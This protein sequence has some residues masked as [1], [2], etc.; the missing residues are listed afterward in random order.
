MGDRLVVSVTADRFVKK[1]PGRPVFCAED[2]ARMLRALRVVDEVVVADAA[3]AVPVI[4]QLRP[5]VYVK[6]SDY[7]EYDGAGY[8]EEERAAVLA[9]GGELRFTTGRAMSSTAIINQHRPVVS[10]DAQTFLGRFSRRYSIDRVHGWLDR[11]ASLRVA[12]YGEH[13]ID[14]Y[15][16]VEPRGKASKEPIVTFKRDG[17]ER[18]P[19]GAM[20]VANHLRAIGCQVD[21]HV[22]KPLVKR[23][24]VTKPFYQKIFSVVQKEWLW[25]GIENGSIAK[26]GDYDLVVAADFG[27]GALGQWEIQELKRLAKRIALTAQSNSLN[28]GFNPLTRWGHVKGLVV[29]DNVEVRLAMQ[30]KGGDL[31]DV[32]K[33]LKAA[34]GARACIATIGHE[35]CLMA[36]S[37]AMH[38]IP[39]FSDKIVDRMGAGDAF[40]AYAAAIDAVGAPLEVTGFVG[41]IAGALKIQT[42]GNSEPVK[43]QDV[44]QWVTGL[45]K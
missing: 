35:G 34:M 32:L 19:G 24:Y 11:A 27:H 29:G 43:A 4:Q 20:A 25:G 40:L 14:E 41:N 13:I 36:G 28:F 26:A 21:T 10:S 8:L 30:D 31:A 15:V 22:S 7:Q 18:F 33:R 5:A 17:V 39:A 1:G 2:R 9:C 12:V 44:K 6:G 3:S 16:Y 23:R 42:V 38:R 37:R 45:L